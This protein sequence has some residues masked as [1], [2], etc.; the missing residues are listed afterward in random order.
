ME[1]SAAVTSNF[2]DGQI[3]NGQTR[4][5]NIISP[6][7]GQLLSKVG[8]SNQQDLDSAVT[9]AKKAFPN[10]SKRTLKQR[11]QVFYNFR[12]LLIDHLEELGQMI[13][14]ENGKNARRGEGRSHE[15]DRINR[16][17]LFLTSVY[18]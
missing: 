1:N 13:H 6:V 11:V 14:L 7:D 5:L 8:L 12:Q 3:A 16:I 9:A 17:C 4:H 18:Q 15:R 2:I 10:W